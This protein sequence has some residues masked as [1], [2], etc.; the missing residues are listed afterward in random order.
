MNHSDLHHLNPFQKDLE[1]ILKNFDRILVPEMNLGQLSSLLRAE[2]LVDTIPFSKVQGRP[3]LISEI[4]NKVLE[5][6]AEK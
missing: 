6:L 1:V 5:L 2:F 4:R 3:F